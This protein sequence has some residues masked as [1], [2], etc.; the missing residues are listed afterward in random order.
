MI[1]RNNQKNYDFSAI[2]SLYSF[3][4]WCSQCVYNGYM[5]PA[6]ELLKS[7]IFSLDSSY[8]ELIKR[9]FDQLMIIFIAKANEK[10]KFEISDYFLEYAKIVPCPVLISHFL[11]NLWSESS[12]KKSQKFSEFL[13][14]LAKIVHQDYFDEETVFQI[15]SL[16]QS[17]ILKLNFD[18]LNFI[19]SLN[20]FSPR[21]AK[22]FIPN[23][24]NSIIPLILEN[25]NKIEIEKP[26][27]SSV[28]S[29]YLNSNTPFTVTII[30]NLHIPFDFLPKDTLTR[31][32]NPTRIYSF[33]P[34]INL[35]TLIDSKLLQPLNKV[36]YIMSH[37]PNYLEMFL[38]SFFD[39]LRVYYHSD[40]FPSFYVTLVYICNTILHSSLFTFPTELCIRFYDEKIFDPT[41]SLLNKSD[42]SF[43]LLHTI[44]ALS[45]DIILSDSG[46]ALNTLLNTTISEK[47]LLLNE[48]IQR[49]CQVATT[50][51][52]KIDTT[53]ELINTLITIAANYQQI[54]LETEESNLPLI[55]QTRESFFSL[56]GHLFSNPPTCTQFFFNRTFASQFLAFSF[57]RR[58]SNFVFQY[59]RQFL[60]HVPPEIMENMPKSLMEFFIVLADT[61]QNRRTHHILLGL[62]S[63]V[64]EGLMNHP[65]IKPYFSDVCSVLLRILPAISQ[66]T[67]KNENELEKSINKDDTPYSNV[68]NGFMSKE[69]AKALLQEIINFAAQTASY[70]FLTALQVDLL[71]DAIQS[72]NDEN[73]VISFYTKF[74]QLLA[75][76]NLPSIKPCF[77]VRQPHVF[78]L[79]VRVL[80]YTSK[81]TEILEYVIELCKFSQININ[82]CAI[83]EIDLF[84]LDVLKK[85]KKEEK[86]SKK[87]VELIL[88]LFSHLSLRHSSSHAVIEFIKLL[89]SYDNNKVN[90]H[91]NLLLNTL[92]SI[93]INSLSEPYSTFSLTSNPYE[94]PIKPDPELLKGFTFSC[95]YNIEQTSK[96]YNPDIFAMKLGN[97]IIC[98]A[99]ISNNSIVC[100]Q[101]DYVNES[102]GNVLDSIELNSW[103]FLT[104]TFSFKPDKTTIR[105]DIDLNQGKKIIMIKLENTIPLNDWSIV[106][107][108]GDAAKIQFPG[109][110]AQCG[111]FRKLKRDQKISLF[112]LGKRTIEKLPATPVKFFFDFGSRSNSETTG[113]LDILTLKCGL[114][115]LL[116]ILKITQGTFSDGSPFELPLD[117]L[118]QL[119]SR[120]LTSS[121]IAQKKFYFDNGISIMAHLISE[122]N[123]DSFTI[124]TYKVLWNLMQS[125]RYEDLQK[126]LFTQIL[127]NFAFIRKLEETIQLRCLKIWHQSLLESFHQFAID[128]GSYDMILP[129]IHQIYLKE[130]EKL[131]R[132]YLFRILKSY[133]EMHGLDIKF[134]ENIFAHGLLCSIVEVNGEINQFIMNIIQEYSPIISFKFHSNIFVFYIR[135]FLEHPNE[136][137][138]LQVLQI[139]VCAIQNRIISL[140]YAHNV[141]YMLIDNYPANSVSKQNFDYI[142]SNIQTC[143][144]ML[145]MLCYLAYR[146][147]NTYIDSIFSSIEPSVEFAIGSIWAVWPLILC[148][149]S[150]P[151]QQD[152]ILTFLICCG[153]NNLCR[154]YS[155]FEYA[156]GSQSILEEMRYKFISLMYATITEPSDDFFEISQYL[157]L[158]NTRIPQQ[159]ISKSSSN[160]Q[161]FPDTASLLN[162]R[163]RK[164]Y[165]VGS[166]NQAEMAGIVPCSLE[167]I[168]DQPLDIPQ[169]AFKLKID[170]K[171]G[172]HHLSL[173]IHCLELYTKLPKSSAEKYLDF[174]L[175][176]SGFLEATEFDGVINFLKMLKFTENEINDHKLPISLI[177]YHEF[178][179][180]KPLAFD[181]WGLNKIYS[182]LCKKVN[183]EMISDI[184]RPRNLEKI[185]K[186]SFSD[187][188]SY[189]KRL[190]FHSQD[191]KNSNMMI[192][193]HKS[194]NQTE[195]LKDTMDNSLKRNRH[196]FERIWEIFSFE[197]AP[198]HN[199]NNSHPKYI[200]NT[201]LTPLVPTTLARAFPILHDSFV[202]NET[203]LEA[204][205]FL[206]SAGKRIP[207]TFKLTNTDFIMRNK[208]ITETIWLSNMKF[209]IPRLNGFE[210]ESKQNLI[211]CIEMKD[212]Q[213]MIKK[214][215]KTVKVL[216]VNIELPKLTKKWCE[217]K[218][219]TFRYLM[220]LN[221]L[222][223]RSFCDIANYPIAPW[224]ACD[225][226]GVEMV[227]ELAIRYNKLSEESALYYLKS[228]EPYKTLHQNKSLELSKLSESRS[229]EL[230]L[231]ES[232]SVEFK[233]SE[234]K[235]IEINKSAEINKTGERVE[236]KD[237]KDLNEMYN[238]T[239]EDLIPEFYCMPEI[240]T[241]LALPKFAESKIDFVY[242]F[243]QAL[244][245]K[246]TSG[247]LPNWF[248]IAFPRLFNNGSHPPRMASPNKRRA[249]EIFDVLAAETNANSNISYETAAFLST[250][251]F[252]DNQNPGVSKVLLFSTSGRC[253]LLNATLQNK[254]NVELSSST[255]DVFINK[256]KANEFGFRRKKVQQF[257]NP[258][259]I[260]IS[261]HSGNIAV[262]HNG[263]VFLI[264]DNGGNFYSNKLQCHDAKKICVDGS[265]TSV[266]CANSDIVVF[267]DLQLFCTIRLFEYKISLI[268]T[269][270]SFKCVVCSHENK[271]FICDIISGSVSK[272]IKCDYEPTKLKITDSWGFILA[273]G[274]NQ[275]VTIFTIN[276]DFIR[277]VKLGFK[278]D[279]W[280]NCRS[281]SGFDYLFM[282]SEDNKITCAE[283]Y[284]MN[285]SH[286]IFE[287]PNK[288][289]D[290]EYNEESNIITAFTK[291]G[292][293]LYIPYVYAQ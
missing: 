226:H 17:L 207:M 196:I 285:P 139:F 263:D 185:M 3:I 177:R 195:M 154:L 215:S 155:Q 219:S 286:T 197:N 33:P 191:F 208:T 99:S 119:F 61:V 15:V 8:C 12:I 216:N 91:E 277:K 287:S 223:G 63:A 110:I 38:K 176:L 199:G 128:F 180:N 251:L 105:H 11:K 168:I 248:L 183:F 29:G 242:K 225:F 7:F 209:I 50:L 271:L 60:I 148:L 198:W 89:S 292:R 232:K 64:N 190:K 230:I 143:P 211:S 135:F 146:L 78:K 261:K 51:I 172:W 71:I 83:S 140:E 136:F 237:F 130:T 45:M 175:V 123:N 68:D 253:C 171:N 32:F 107:G 13:G 116:P 4:A 114:I 256:Q 137:L 86:L 35:E 166:N 84:L 103:H 165:A 66:N 109:R 161:L 170:D 115:T 158:F 288:L 1:D 28:E 58:L 122:Y 246:E 85:D 224:I 293:M 210:I 250:K 204:K 117:N 241:G 102:T 97:E 90:K 69:T 189:L 213:T 133:I 20:H 67:L 41:I 134:F 221:R 31:D 245:G 47:P 75:G 178:I 21:C 234:S 52:Q 111:L 101:D 65:Q 131:H 222:I 125:L 266:F 284:F 76:E 59:F 70:I 144:V 290:V 182:P 132:Q 16:I 240:L 276:G 247:I 104:I 255:K 259:N 202:N 27:I 289:Y 203:L 126:Q 80:F 229:V 22:L 138:R 55:L 160:H 283:A 36:I 73:Y 169:I 217:Y 278:L 156:I 275:E 127:A 181:D 235:S 87:S 49:L 218:I 238:N 53:P 42:S 94:T 57:E 37:N 173:A 272:I 98:K 30:P 179:S 19:G 14:K 62:L 186:Q 274:G 187:I 48:F 214:L 281:L 113:F 44:R 239:K 150:R 6:T 254:K 25:K 233:L 40:H 231:N 212:F 142:L 192:Y 243:R 124:K 205:G 267:F 141:V 2:L 82:T 18:A 220:A 157:F 249:S 108:G 95:W 244:E 188:T 159:S 280:V 265:W 23:F 147:G 88:D 162:S 151:N 106:F 96:K 193:I 200:R 282:V 74:I 194:L 167:E 273:Y 291:N 34:T 262:L 81:Q 153:V 206:L 149:R 100:I 118:L 77:I 26:E 129:A 264:S 72:I 257:P 79:F 269:S 24:G 164:S 174:I 184:L 56:F 228:I 121:I 46:A 93:T 120:I 252:Q 201:V 163:R 258:K 10:E 152:K 236:R 145:P 9:T 54:E 92:S 279:L 268:E 227:S 112:E 43:S 39:S 5:P 270:R 260:F